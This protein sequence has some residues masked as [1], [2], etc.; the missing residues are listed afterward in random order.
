V[1]VLSNAGLQIPVIPLL[2]VVGNADNISPEQIAATGVNI[3]VMIGFTVIVILVA[4]AHSPIVG[5]KRYKVVV[6]LSNAGLHTPVIPLL[7]V[8]G[9]ADNVSPV[10]I[11]TT[12]VNVGVTI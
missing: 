8:V 12:G 10:Q 1:V 3:G 11:A 5:V 2:E 7:E 4:T 6:V 9:N